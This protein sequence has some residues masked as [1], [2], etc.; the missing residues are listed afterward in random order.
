MKK[1]ILPSLVATFLLSGCGGSDSSSPGP[2][3]PRYNWQII[4]LQTLK[5]S[6][7][8]SG[9]VIYG[10]SE[11]DN[12][13]VITASIANTGYNVLFHNAD[14]SIIEEHTIQAADVPSNGIVNFDSGWVPDE[15]YVSLEEVDRN[16]SGEP[17][18]YMYSV[19]K[20][21]LGN[22][23]LNVRSSQTGSNCYAG[24]DYRSVTDIS[25]TAALSVLQ[26]S[27]VSYYQ[28]SYS[29]DLVSGHDLSAHIPVRSPLPAV[30]DTLV[31]AFYSSQNGQHTD[32]AYFGFLEPSYVY[33]TDENNDIVAASLSNADLEPM[34]W[35]V[36][37]NLAVDDGSSVLAI[38][39]NNSYQWQTLYKD[40]DQFTIAP[41]Y[42]QVSHWVGL[43]SGTTNDSNWQFN[44]VMAINADNAALDL[45]LAELNSIDNLDLIENCS[46]ELSHANHCIDN[47]NS[48]NSSDFALQRSQVRLRSHNNSRTFYQ[49]IYAAPKAQQ[50]LMQSSA[51]ELATSQIDS[52]EIALIDSELSADQQDYF[53]ANFIDSRS[54]AETG[55]VTQYSDANGLILNP[56]EYEDLYLEMLKDSATIVQNAK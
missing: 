12:S 28:T 10:T 51:L 30:K 39:N 54:I 34:Y 42:D 53:M 55:T 17:D 2:S 38:H 43:F 45:E 46:V 31:T 35:Q 50:A 21:Y 5:E 23:V 15:G 36:A 33:D 52:I 18:V 14:G 29:A 27:G 49:S 37:S 48:F 13:R 20:Q 26:E 1:A 19:Q 6:D 32:L 56:T 11:T 22:K 4:Q 25:D 9:C 40:V 47:A 16:L 7:V 3:T 8:K 41:N 44:S 24:K